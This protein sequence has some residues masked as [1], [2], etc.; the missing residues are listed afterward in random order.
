MLSPPLPLTAPQVNVI[1][2]SLTPVQHLYLY[3]ALKGLS[4]AALQAAITGLLSKVLLSER[5]NTV[6]TALSGGQKR[7]LCLAISLIGNSRTIFLDEPT[8]GMDPHSRRSIWQVYAAYRYTPLHTVTSSYSR[9]S[10]HVHASGHSEPHARPSH[11]LAYLRCPCAARVTLTCLLS[12]ISRPPSC[13][14]LL[15]EQR[16]GRTIVLT[17]HFLDEAEILSD[18]IA[19]MAEG[20]L[21]C[22]GTVRRPLFDSSQHF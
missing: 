15:R 6:S 7:K 1:F 19:I 3:G 18:R 4:G 12:S 11:Q 14:Q 13:R 5:A 17:T 21:R 10:W 16:E 8:S 9:S 2:E 20:S 22:F